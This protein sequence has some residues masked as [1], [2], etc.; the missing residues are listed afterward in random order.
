[1]KTVRLTYA[2]NTKDEISGVK[3]VSYGTVCFAIETVS[4][5]AI[6]IPIANVYCV[7]VEDDK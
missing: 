7:T 3:N 4:G 6:Y 1:V 5:V 2:D